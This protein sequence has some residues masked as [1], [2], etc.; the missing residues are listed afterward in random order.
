[1]SWAILQE[2]G[3]KQFFIQLKGRVKIGKQLVQI[4]PDIEYSKVYKVQD[5]RAELA[6][7]ESLAAEEAGSGNNKTFIDS[8]TAQ[9]LNQG[10]VLEI[11]TEQG[12]EAVVEQLIQNSSTFSKKSSFAQEKYIKKKKNKHLSL[13]R[14]L[15]ATCGNIADTL[16]Q[17]KPQKSLKSEAL[18]NMLTLANIHYFSKV[19]LNDHTGG[20]LIG[21]VLERTS[22]PLT[23]VYSEK[24]KDHALKYFGIR[25]KPNDMLNYLTIDCVEEEFDSLIFTGKD[26]EQFKLMMAKLKGAGAFVAYFQDVVLAAEVCDWLMKENNSVNIMFEEIWSREFQVLPQRTHPDMK[27]RT[28]TSAGY[29]VSGVKVLN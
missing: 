23:C 5:G 19:I 18:F 15:Q 4:S 21:S 7:A 25:K 9:T 29:L 3:G 28:G 12:G 24:V 16:Y 8:N 20:V 13:F 26:L 2:L 22:Q 27:L 11:R 17:L 10:Q 14:V 6:D 1:M